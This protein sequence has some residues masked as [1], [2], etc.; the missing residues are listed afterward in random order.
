MYITNVHQL[1]YP[2][3]SCLACLLHVCFGDA[4]V[5]RTLQWSF[6][7]SHERLLYS[8]TNNCIAKADMMHFQKCLVI[9]LLLLSPNPFAHEDNGSDTQG[10]SGQNYKPEKGERGSQSSNPG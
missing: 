5:C 9:T 6:L 3:F 7:H 1:P 10:C 2:L 4:I 8:V